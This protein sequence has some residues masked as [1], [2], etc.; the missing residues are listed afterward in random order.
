[1]E[2][3]RT[4]RGHAIFG[5]YRYCLADRGAQAEEGWR[6]THKL[7]ALVDY[8]KTDGATDKNQ[9]QLGV[10]S[11]YRLNQRLFV[12]GSAQVLRDRFAGFTS[13]VSLSGGAASSW[14]APRASRSTSRRARPGGAPTISTSPPPIP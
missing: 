13:Q 4:D 14:S 5:Q 12:Y 2:G 11:D 9:M 10:E 6:W 8:D 3:R 7:S 1:V